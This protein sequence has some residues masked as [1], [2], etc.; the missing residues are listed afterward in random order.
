MKVFY[1]TSPGVAK[2]DYVAEKF[3][4]IEFKDGY[5]PIT[6]D[7]IWRSRD[8]TGPA[9]MF[10]WQGRS[11]PEGQDPRRVPF[12]MKETNRLKDNGQP[13]HVSRLWLRWLR[14]GA[15]FTIY[16]VIL[17]IFLYIILVIARGG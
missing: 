8:G 14:H 12:I 16:G 17:T 6:N 7:A 10:V 13:L 5:H 9:V 2:V 1:L 4:L 15:F 3:R 11:S